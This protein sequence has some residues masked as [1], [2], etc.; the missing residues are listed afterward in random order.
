MTSKTLPY[1]GRFAPS[2]TGPLHTGS[3]LTALAS[4]LDAK[5][6]HGLWLVRMEDLDPP[7]EM[8]GAAE[9][10]LES[11]QHYG[12]HWDGDV[13][14]QSQ[15]HQQYQQAVDQLIAQGL[16]FYCTCSRSQILA[17]SGSN[18]YP[19]TCRNCSTPPNVPHA[20]RLQINDIDISFLDSL[21]G[22]QRCNLFQESGDFVIK[23]KEGL[24]AYHLAV[25]LDD[26]AQGITHIVRGC[27]L[28]DSSFRH[29]YLQQV[30]NLPTPQYTHL[31]VIVNEEG[32]KLSK[33]TYAEAIPHDNPTPLLL[34]CLELLGQ[35]PPSTLKQAPAS[36]LLQWGIEH[37]QQHNIPPIRA[38]HPSAS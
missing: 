30:L 21:Q 10:I 20:V 5:A 35:Q 38:L 17:A 22:L 24:F 23:R 13:W 7:R 6:N 12:L 15:R 27:D 19:G 3:L 28:L 37:W 34:H 33:Q 25:V 16:A 26:A 1:V 18:R 4:Y 11:L 29:I 36:E 9:Q 31:P 14:Y 2:P 8:A 32:Q